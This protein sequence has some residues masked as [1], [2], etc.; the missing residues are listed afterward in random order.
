MLKKFVAARKSLQCPLT[1]NLR[2]GI[3]QIKADIWAVRASDEHFNRRNAVLISGH[4]ELPKILIPEAFKNTDIY[5]LDWKGET[6]S[7]QRCAELILK[8]MSQG[9]KIKTI[10]V[11]DS[12]MLDNE[13]LE[14]ISYCIDNILPSTS[15]VFISSKPEISPFVRHLLDVKLDFRASSSEERYGLEAIKFFRESFRQ[16]ADM[17]L[18]DLFFTDLKKEFTNLSPDAVA[19]VLDAFWH[20][21]N[22]ARFAGVYL[23]TDEF[24]LSLYHQAFQQASSH[25]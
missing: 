24:R 6:F 16:M 22:E 9:T 23:N 2:I 10:C 20:Q 3:E 5:S 8:P 15:F 17:T 1:P 7:R 12:E 13:K 4:H 14:Y 19:Q 18:S 21:Y 11:F 25:W